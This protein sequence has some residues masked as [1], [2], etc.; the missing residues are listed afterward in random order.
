MM[1]WIV[2]YICV[3]ALNYYIHFYGAKHVY[4]M[5]KG[6]ICYIFNKRK[7]WCGKYLILCV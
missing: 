2:L 1:V 5:L 7:C 4:S 3:N 6:Q